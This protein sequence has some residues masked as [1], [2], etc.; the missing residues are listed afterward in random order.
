MSTNYNG[1][2]SN[3]NNNSHHSNGYS[4]TNNGHHQEWVDMTMA[5]NTT[6]LNHGQYPPVVVA[7]DSSNKQAMQPTISVNEITTHILVGLSSEQIQLVLQT[8]Q[9]Y[10]D[11]MKQDTAKEKEL[12]ELQEKEAKLERQ[13]KL[14]AENLA[15]LHYKLDALLNNR[16][17]PSEIRAGNNNASVANNGTAISNSQPSVATGGNSSPSST[18]GSNPSNSNGDNAPKQSQPLDGPLSDEDMESLLKNLYE[19]W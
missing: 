19:A 11:L 4:D 12:V 3:S 7:S 14:L 18:S 6:N 5:N 15:E 8:K 2:Y 16:I 17:S 10:E 1:D 13:R 9:Q